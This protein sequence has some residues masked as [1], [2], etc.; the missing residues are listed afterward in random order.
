MKTF[1]NTLFRAYYPAERLKMKRT[2]ARKLF[3]VMPV[4]T[5]ALVFALSGR[6]VVINGYNWW[7]MMLLPGVLTLVCCMTGQTDRRLGNRAISAL[8]IDLK[9]VWDAKVLVCIKAVILGNVV[10]YLTV[11]AAGILI[12]QISN[13]DGIHVITPQ[14]GVLAV[15]VMT[16][17][18]IWQVPLCLW[19]NERFGLYLTLFVNVALNVGSAIIVSLKDYWF[20]NPYAVTSRAMCP[21]L[22]VLPN[23]LIARPGSVTYT[24]ELM[25]VQMIPAGICICLLCLALLWAVS[26][27]WYEKKGVQAV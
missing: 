7:Y 4:L 8:P 25:K 6:Y 2:V 22:K 20:V 13:M 27:K 15:L 19:M 1:S 3:F 5:V 14:Q 26:R 16:V 23:G 11:T 10:L 24:P 21:I 9:Q 17:G 18:C 12:N